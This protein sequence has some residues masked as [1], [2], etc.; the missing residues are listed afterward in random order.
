MVEWRNVD[1]DGMY[2]DKQR[3]VV[4][5]SAIEISG[6]ESI[7]DACEQVFHVLAFSAQSRTTTPARSGIAP[8]AGTPP[9]SDLRARDESATLPR[10]APPPPR[11]SKHPTLR[12][13]PSP[14]RTSS[15]DSDLP[16]TSMNATPPP[17]D[18][19]SYDS[20][21][22]H[23]NAQ[24]PPAFACWHCKTPLYPTTPQCARCQAL[25]TPQGWQRRTG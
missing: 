16:P 10:S 2:A 18:V 15:L 23:A 22:V 19:V 21:V 7:I 14:L 11:A 5:T 17:P 8:S 24:R 20:Y 13:T 4:G 1:P 6:D 3:L 12:P 9:A 25:P